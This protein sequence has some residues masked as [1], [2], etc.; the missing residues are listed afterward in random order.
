M[1]AKRW[2]I[3]TTDP[4]HVTQ[5]ENEYRVTRPLAMALASRGVSL[6]AI[7][8]FLQPKLQDLSDPFLL[9][10]TKAAAERLWSAIQNHERILIFGDYDTDGVTSTAL[11]AWILK[12]SGAL[13]DCFLPHRT[14]DGYGLSVQTVERTVTDHKVI[15]TVDC[16][17]TSYEATETA[18]Q[19]GIDVIITDHHKPGNRLPPALAVINP[20][21]HD[22]V[23]WLHVLAGVGVCF[24]LCHAFLKYGLQH[25]LCASAIDL[26]EGLD[27]VA[28]GTVA[29]IVPLVGENRCL[30][31]HGMRVLEQQQRPGIRALCDIA[32]VGDQVNSGDIP[33][34]LAPRLNAA[35][36]LGS[37]IDALRLLQASEI[38]DAYSL[39]R[40]LDRYNRQRQSCENGVFLVAKEAIQQLNLNETRAIIVADRDWHRGV[41]GIVASRL[42]QQYHRPV[43]ILSI[44]DDGA[45][46]GSGRSVRGID[47]VAM[48]SACAEFLDSYGGHPMAAG[49]TLTTS[50]LTQFKTAF[51]SAVVRACAAG[52][53]LTPVLELDGTVSLSSLDTQ[54][55]SELNML[56]P[57]GHGNPAPVFHITNLRAENLAVVGKHHT[58]GRVHD[59]SGAQ[60]PFIAFGRTPTTF[61]DGRWEIA[62]RPQ[63]NCYHGQECA[64]LEIIDVRQAS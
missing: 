54:F 46:A 44:G 47:L 1:I 17:I 29:D 7:G 57:F 49:L 41:I 9:P 31:T 32:G 64:Q 55:F 23:E 10:G 51:E 59:D 45:V 39:A 40:T 56:Q 15:V 61:P 8:A 62:A 35:G 37:A 24:K 16:G 14:E 53:D 38:V 6:S 13:V 42:T 34:K 63:I 33:F 48:L 27:L 11:L 22:G 30:V 20:K 28:L 3:A 58:R 36:R 12:E 43:V 25:R 50:T 26:K 4:T 5:I 19:L 60:L 2:V 18:N 52:A 21:L